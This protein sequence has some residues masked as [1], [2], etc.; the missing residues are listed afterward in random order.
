MRVFLVIAAVVVLSTL[1]VGTSGSDKAEILKER[2]AQ[3]RELREKYETERLKLLQR[4]NSLRERKIRLTDSKEEMKKEVFS[5][6]QIVN[7]LKKSSLKWREEL[8]LLEKSLE[9][10]NALMTEREAALMQRIEKG[11]PYLVEERLSSFSVSQKEEREKSPQRR[12]DG[13]LDAYAKEL[14]IVQSWEAYRDFLD[15]P[16]GRK[17][18]G[19]ILRAG[20]MILFF[21]SD[22]GEVA[23]CFGGDR[24]N[25]TWRFVKDG[26]LYR[27]LR[28]A[29]RYV[30]RQ[31]IPN[32]IAIPIPREMVKE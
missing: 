8:S 23:F 16:D 9:E 31:T 4:I 6:E 13:L 27:R 17:L 24:G 5:N 22:S 19:Y 11:L 14:R 10:I 3:L 20:M 7:E 15:H 18:R 28:D 29:V 1:V 26:G 30:R 21:V 25:A 32:V 2:A 12:L